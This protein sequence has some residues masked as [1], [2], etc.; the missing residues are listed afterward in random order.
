VPPPS[1]GRRDWHN[2]ERERAGVRKGQRKIN[3]IYSAFNPGFGL[4]RLGVPARYMGYYKGGKEV[5]I[6]K[7]HWRSF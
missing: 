5:E 2:I 6:G 1:V 4:T 3:N 7:G